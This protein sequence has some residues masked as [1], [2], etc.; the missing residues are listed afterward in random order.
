MTRHAE[1]ARLR[2]RVTDAVVERHLES[3]K[4]TDGDD[5]SA[6]RPTHRRGDRLDAMKRRAQIKTDNPIPVFLGRRLDCGWRSAARDADKNIDAA[7]VTLDLFDGIMD[8][9]RPQKIQLMGREA[10]ACFGFQFLEPNTVTIESRDRR[11]VFQKR[12]HGCRTD[13]A[14]TARHDRNLSAEIRNHT[15]SPRLLFSGGRKMI[16][17]NGMIRTDT[18]LAKRRRSHA[19]GDMPT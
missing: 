13:A 2:R 7:T 4:R 19:K 6:S 15:S 5:P 14:G 18:K 17:L 11:A 10:G 3:R 8:L 9:F 16:L 12:Q 1:D